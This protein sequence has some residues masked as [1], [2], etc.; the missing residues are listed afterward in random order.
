MA[1][2][3]QPRWEGFVGFCSWEACGR[4]KKTLKLSAVNLNCV[5]DKA[6]TQWG[7]IGSLAEPLCKV[8]SFPQQSKASFTSNAVEDFEYKLSI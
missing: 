6:S 7:L 1:C 3:V 8:N 4:V 5:D 2:R